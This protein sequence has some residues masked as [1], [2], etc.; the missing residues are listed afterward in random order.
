MRR[1]SRDSEETGR[2]E[3]EGQLRR[4]NP[5]SKRNLKKGGFQVGFGD[6]VLTVPDLG[7]RV[8]VFFGTCLRQ[9]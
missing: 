2:E 4:K 8:S 3:S 5:K 7:Q 6:G 9:A 1:N